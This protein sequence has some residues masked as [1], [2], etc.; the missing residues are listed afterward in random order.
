MKKYLKIIVILIG[1]ILIINTTKCLSYS[2]ETDNISIQ[3]NEKY[4][5][6][7][8]TV[9][10]DEE[11]KFL[12][13]LKD[14]YVV[15]GT[16]YILT[17][18]KKDGGNE[19]YKKEIVTSK[20]ITTKTSNRERILNELPET[21]EYNENGYVGEY[22][23]NKDNMEIK[24]NYN[25]YTEYLIEENKQYSNLERNDL[26]FI[27]KQIV[28]D[29]VALD[30]LK[31]EWQVQTTKKIGDKEVADKYIANCY[32]S[33]KIKKDNPYTYTVTATY[34]GIAEKIEKKPY[35][36]T[37]TYKVEEQEAIQEKSEK[38]ILPIF[39]GTGA[40]II[41]VVF[42]IIRKNTKVYNLQY[43][44][45]KMVGKLHIR[46]SIIDITR[47]KD[48]EVTNRYKIKLSK[49]LVKKFK[50]SNIQIVKGSN[51]IEHKIKAENEPYTFEITI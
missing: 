47:F 20:Q 23:I 2:L 18:I 12:Q 3:N 50:Y 34:S 1:Y 13:S 30:L 51:I 46:K 6:K 10:A 17:D 25:G 11:D 22:K 36:Y 15:D 31:T 14:D 9:T 16:K 38:N 45:W 33:G 41:I 27:P 37:V 19:L 4:N 32:Y 26:D 42:F 7:T 43:G 48:L 40:G 39:G 21:I 24:S 49:N 44:Y 29:E 5:I 8:Y 35:I 28:K